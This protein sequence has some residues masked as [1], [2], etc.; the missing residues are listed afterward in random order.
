MQ[1]SIAPHETLEPDGSN[2]QQALM[3]LQNKGLIWKE[4]RGV[5]AIEE[6]S[7]MDL[8]RQQGML[9]MVP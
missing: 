3:A 4:T 1:R 9:D 6:G 5:Y 7:T 8:M 2:V